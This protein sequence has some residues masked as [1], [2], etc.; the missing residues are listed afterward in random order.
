MKKIFS[1]LLFCLGLTFT[2]AAQPIVYSGTYSAEL[3]AAG[4]TYIYPLKSN[5]D[6]ITFNQLGVMSTVCTVDSTSGNGNGTIVLQYCETLANGTGNGHW[7][8]ID[9]TTITA[10]PTGS[11][12]TVTN[13]FGSRRIRA[14]CTQSGTGGTEYF[15]RMSYMNWPW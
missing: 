6:T 13:P 7:V 12:R 9:T 14:K 15:L 5:G 8:D 1:L 10:E 11:S 4:T 2:I 3:A